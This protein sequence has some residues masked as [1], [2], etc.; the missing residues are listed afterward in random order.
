MQK[1][2]EGIMSYDKWY[3]RSK[4][5]ASGDEDKISE[6]TAY[7]ELYDEYFNKYI[8]PYLEAS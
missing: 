5:D 4:L 2:N 1:D 3:I 6:S 8:I 7:D